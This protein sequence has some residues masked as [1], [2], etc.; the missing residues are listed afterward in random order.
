MA[1][2]LGWFETKKNWLNVENFLHT[3]HFDA[4]EL[5]YTIS[6]IIMNA[7]DPLE[8]FKNFFW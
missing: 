3:E 1:D 4:S 2:L 8:W 6:L 5:K 7:F